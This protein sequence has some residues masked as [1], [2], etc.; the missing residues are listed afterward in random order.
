MI[1]SEAPTVGTT[2][3]QVHFGS[4]TASQGSL[5][6]WRK[7]RYL[8]ANSLSSAAAEDSFV[9]PAEDA[10]AEADPGRLVEMGMGSNGPLVDRAYA[11]ALPHQYARDL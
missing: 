7:V 6:S 4:G 11:E 3:F 9:D 10:A 1:R 2:S 5:D 8:V